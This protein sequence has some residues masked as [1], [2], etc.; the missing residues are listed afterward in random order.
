MDVFKLCLCSFPSLHILK[1]QQTFDHSVTPSQESN[2]T[3]NLPDGR[4]GHAHSLC[5]S[6]SLILSHMSFPQHV[7]FSISVFLS[8]ELFQIL[9]HDLFRYCMTDMYVVVH[10]YL[11]L[12]SSFFRFWCQSVFISKLIVLCFRLWSV[13]A[14][15]FT[16][17]TK[18]QSL[19]WGIPTWPR[20][21]NRSDAG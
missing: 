11:R 10:G 1:L 4:A 17:Y 20:S 15:E 3:S 16:N 8:L 7:I 13:S 14:S 6:S 21:I 12:H 18:E 19:L 2:T 9:L 5:L